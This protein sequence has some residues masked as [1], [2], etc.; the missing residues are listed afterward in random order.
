[1]RPNAIVRN[2]VFDSARVIKN[3]IG[4]LAGLFKTSAYIVVH[5]GAGKFATCVSR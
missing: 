2:K 5:T 4:K 3:K 1:M